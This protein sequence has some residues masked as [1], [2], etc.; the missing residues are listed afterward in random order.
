LTTKLFF[1]AIV[2]LM[3]SSVPVS[4]SPILLVNASG[5]L[6]G[7]LN[8]V[9]GGTFYDVAFVDTSCVAA[10]SGCDASSDFSFTTAADAQ[11][12]S[13]ALLDQVFVNGPSGNFDTSPALTFGCTSSLV[14]CQAWT[15]YALG[16]QAVALSAL[17][18]NGPGV[19]SDFVAFAGVA[20]SASFAAF[21]DSTL[22]QWTPAAAAVPEPTSMILLGT[23]LAGLAARGYRRARCKRRI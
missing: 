5:V 1:V 22:A 12:A 10:Y 4:A 2:T 17:A 9:V 19:D 14:H 6:T 11:A 23:G 21:V 13:Q 20:N 7:A 3:V 18:T 8:V 15:P 16:G